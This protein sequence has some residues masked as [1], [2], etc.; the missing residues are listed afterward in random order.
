MKKILSL[1]FIF[2]CSAAVYAQDKNNN[3]AVAFETSS[4]TYEEPAVG[5]KL[6]GPK[7]GV[8]AEYFGWNPETGGLFSAAQLVFMTGNVTYNGAL[9]DGTPHTA[10]GIQDYY[11]EGRLLLGFVVKADNIG[12]DFWP[13]LGIGY[14][15]L[16]D[17]MGA[18][19]YGYDRISKYTYIPAGLK[20]RF[21]MINGWTLTLTGE[22]DI[23]LSGKQTSDFGE[24][25]TNN[26]TDGMGARVSARL[27]KNL[28]KVSL[29]AEPF[30]RYWHI[31]DSEVSYSYV[32][33]AYL[34]EP[35]NKTNEYGLKIG[36]A[37]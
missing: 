34:Y 9:M 10:S 31:K 26:Q 11:F 32:L 3:F 1:L 2:F 5:V 21:K 36:V 24:V 20:T 13:Y 25:V 27:A 7:Y 18:D 30:Y 15:Q 22:Y 33:D 4:Y 23:F 16:F 35:E 6:N 8:S 19:Q 28:G 12:T 14:R 17:G 29:F 37:F